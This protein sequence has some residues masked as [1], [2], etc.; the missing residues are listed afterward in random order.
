MTA[1]VLFLNIVSR[2]IQAKEQVMGHS[3]KKR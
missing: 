3:E 1:N 2:A